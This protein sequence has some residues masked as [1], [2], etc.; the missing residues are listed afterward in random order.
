MRYF[1]RAQ[2]LDYLTHEEENGWIIA[3]IKHTDAFVIAQKVTGTSLFF[4][5]R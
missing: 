2:S 4:I 1:F 5:F 3:A